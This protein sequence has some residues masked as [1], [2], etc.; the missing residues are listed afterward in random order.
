MKAS[1]KIILAI[2]LTPII[3]IALYIS[4]L[5]ITYI[6]DVVISGSKYGFTISATD[7]MTYKD[8][9]TIKNKYPNLKVFIIYGPQAGDLLTLSPTKENFKE[10]SKH[11]RWDLLLDGEGEYF[12]IIGLYFQD[13]VL[14][15]IYRHRK[16]FELP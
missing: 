14:D 7:E 2:V 9:A 3:L 15:Q 5:W 10:I 13:G 4:F 6:D 12:N 11:D 1:Y 16:Y 8:I